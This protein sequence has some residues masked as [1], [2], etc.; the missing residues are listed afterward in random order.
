M[1]R[2][3]EY[4]PNQNYF[5]NLVPEETFPSHSFEYFIVTTI[6]Q[7]VDE[8]DYYPDEMDKGGPE[9]HNPKAMLGVL[10]YAYSKGVYSY[11]KMA[12][13]C[14]YDIAFI[15][16]SGYTTP[17]YST[18]SRFVQKFNDQILNLFSLVLYIAA[19]RG[20]VD[21][22]LT[23]TDGTKIIGNASDK[24]SGT[25]EDFKKRSEKL[26]SKIAEMVEKCNQVDDEEAKKYFEAKK[27][28]Y[29]KLN[30]KIDN[31]LKVAKPMVKTDGKEIKQNITD[32]DTRT[33]KVSAHGYK[34]GYNAQAT[35]CGKNG[36]IVGADVTNQAN[37]INQLQPMLALSEKLAPGKLKENFETG[38]HLA[39]NG[40]D[41]VNNAVYADE[42]NLK[43]MI[44]PGTTKELFENGLEGKN[45]IKTIGMKHCKIEKDSD[46]VKIICPGKQVLTKFTFMTSKGETYY[47]FRVYNRKKCEL[48]PFF[49]KCCG[50]LKE[51][52]KK[53]F[54]IKREL[55]DNWELI[56][57]RH[58]EIKSEEGKRIYSKRMGAIEKV[59]G[60][61]KA[62]IGAKQMLVR[63]I[64]KV[65][66][67]WSMLCTAYN[68]YR[69][70]NLSKMENF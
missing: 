66:T 31:F 40:Y 60:H 32:N 30:N 21:Y 37:D 26:K 16:I 55:L 9:A 41:S 57:K 12:R 24:F 13:N 58:D 10:F 59:F 67:V 6:D 39:D 3:K 8:K 45:E 18:I 17:D 51:N 1:K 11:R 49:A 33:M 34:P 65:K 2:F 42:K 22:Q 5:I 53:N 29:E 64:N 14:E 61:I 56:R 27:E 48:C 25:I 63:G 20:F 19:N 68:L 62:N 4:N 54:R 7:I 36:L 52:A 28:R 23:A 44:P 43:V 38:T 50:K 35:V 15:Y 70:F 46:G 47:D 69:I